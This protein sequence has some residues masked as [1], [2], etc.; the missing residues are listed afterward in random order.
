M[1]TPF[2]PPVKALPGANRLK[3][4]DTNVKVPAPVFMVTL[5][6]LASTIK[7]WKVKLL[8]CPALLKPAP[9]TTLPVCA[10]KVFTEVPARLNALAG[11]K[12]MWL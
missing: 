3:L 8:P 2:V 6:A 11:L 10:V 9:K 12:M 5:P 1:T 4:S 7:P